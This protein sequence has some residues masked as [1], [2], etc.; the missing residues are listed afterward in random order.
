MFSKA[1]IVHNFAENESKKSLKT[2]KQII[3]L[4]SV[5]METIEG[6]RLQTSGSRYLN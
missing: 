6:L 3:Y 4:I 2:L 5:D 1:P